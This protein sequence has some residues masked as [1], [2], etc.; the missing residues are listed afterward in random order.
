MEVKVE[1][2][3]KMIKQREIFR[4]ILIITFKKLLNRNLWQRRRQKLPGAT[5][6]AG[7][8]AKVLPESFS[9]T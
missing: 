3:Q 8:D 7:D 2:G 1:V 6:A 5:L 4:A 9:L